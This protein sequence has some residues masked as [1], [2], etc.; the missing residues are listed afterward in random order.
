MNFV[1]ELAQV[2]WSILLRCTVCKGR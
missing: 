1:Q 2:F